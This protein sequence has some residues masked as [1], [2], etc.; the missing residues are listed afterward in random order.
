MT[1]HITLGYP[2]APD[3]VRT[4]GADFILRRMLVDGDNLT[5]AVGEVFE[6]EFLE[7]DRQI[8]ELDCEIDDLERDNDHLS[9]NLNNV[10]ERC[11][12]L[13]NLLNQATA[14]LSD[15]EGAFGTD[16]PLDDYELKE[17]LNYVLSAIVNDEAV[18]NW[19][20]N[21]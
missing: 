13:D 7:L 12:D 19:R 17:R 14:L 3:M 2:M 4:L 20:M 6:N 9:I 16:Q 1:T 5:R 10:E 21:P 11:D 15:I 8:K 18:G